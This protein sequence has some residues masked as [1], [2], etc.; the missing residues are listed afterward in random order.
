MTETAKKNKLAITL[1]EEYYAGLPVDIEEPEPLN[2]GERFSEQ[3]V[4]DYCRNIEALLQFGMI[5]AEKLRK[6]VQII[7]QLQGADMPNIKED[8]ALKPDENGNYAIT[9]KYV[10]RCE[11]RAVEAIADTHPSRDNSAT[12][13]QST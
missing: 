9:Q 6:G 13:K 3:Q 8:S 4:Q 7:K 1:I 12:G 10:D 11:H 2:F 5:N